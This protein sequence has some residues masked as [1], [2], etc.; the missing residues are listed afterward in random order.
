[1]DPAAWM[2]LYVVLVV[3]SEEACANRLMA[4]D[5]RKK[6]NTNVRKIQK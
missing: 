6:K 5:E 4:T 1:L 3:D 2:T